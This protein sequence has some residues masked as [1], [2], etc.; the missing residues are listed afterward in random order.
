MESNIILNI[1]DIENGFEVHVIKMN[2]GTFNVKIYDT[3]VNKYFECG[4]IF[5]LEKQAVDYAKTLV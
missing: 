3:D 2:N 4:K 5:K 1:Q